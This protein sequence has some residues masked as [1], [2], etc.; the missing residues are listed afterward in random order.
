[1]D[2]IAIAI[3]DENPIL[4]EALSSLFTNKGMKIAALGRS[5]ADAIKFATSHC[6]DILI[7]DPTKPGGMEAISTVLLHASNTKVIAYSPA[8]GADYAV[9]AIEAGA[10]GYILNKCTADEFIAAIKSVMDGDTFITPSFAATI[11]AALRDDR[12]RKR[13]AELV[14]LSIRENQIVRLLLRGRTNKEIANNLAISEKTVKCYMTT[15]MQKLNARNRTEVV[16][17][18]QKIGIHHEL[19][20]GANLA[21]Q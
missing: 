18:C 13:A 7:L 15:L 1:M 17:A 12:V 21:S 2:P 20:A 11:M 3:V 14:D 16:L 6:P 8:I 10:R 19:E 5:P 4:L 9:R